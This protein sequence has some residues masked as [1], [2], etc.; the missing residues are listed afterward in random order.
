MQYWLDKAVLGGLFGGWYVANIV[1]N[2]YNKQALLAFPQP[3]TMTT[4]QVRQAF[5]L[6]SM[7]LL[8]MAL[9][10]RWHRPV[11]TALG[12]AIR[13]PYFARCHCCLPLCLR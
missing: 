10:P 11:M 13:L 4:L 8:R 9:V 1:F 7:C 12:A 5:T 2:L 6:L 3:L